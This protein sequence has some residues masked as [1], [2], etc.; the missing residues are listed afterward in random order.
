MSKMNRKEIKYNLIE[1]IVAWSHG[2]YSRDDL[3]RLTMPELEEI[4]AEIYFQRICEI[5]QL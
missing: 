5:E 1:S 4:Y 2:Q 3:A